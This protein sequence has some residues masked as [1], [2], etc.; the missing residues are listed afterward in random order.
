MTV[1]DMCTQDFSPANYEAPAMLAGSKQYM[2]RRFVGS[3]FTDLTTTAS[4]SFKIFKIDK[5]MMVPIVYTIVT[6]ADDTSITLDIGYTD[7]TNTA[8]TAFEGD[9][10]LD[11]TGVTASSDDTIFFDD[12]GYYITLVLS[13][14]A[15]LDDAT[16]FTV[17][18]G[19]LDLSDAGVTTEITAPV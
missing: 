11:S 14:L 10:A 2:R 18:V 7:G 8:A 5:H 6:D 12:D 19:V 15:D 17:V 4:D 16:E 3:D 9:A 1:Y 13:N